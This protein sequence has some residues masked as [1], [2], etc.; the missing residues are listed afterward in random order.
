M[1]DGCLKNSCPLNQISENLGLLSPCIRCVAHATDGTIKQMV[2]SRSMHVPEISEFLPSLRTII[3]H[4]QISGKSL[5]L[6]NEALHV[7]EMKSLHLM[8]FCP[9]QMSYL[10]TAAAAQSVK[11]L[12][13]IC[14]VL[15]SAGMKPVL[16]FQNQ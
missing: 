2:N 12:V 4:F 10:L 14:D 8:T 7:L 15:A 6:L 5:D 16:Y 1:A 11:L 3:C 13:P 9:I